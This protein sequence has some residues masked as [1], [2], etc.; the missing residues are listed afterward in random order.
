L[1]TSSGS[2]VTQGLKGGLDDVVGV[3]P[4]DQV[5]V[6]VYP[7]VYDEGPEK[8]LDEPGVEM[9]DHRLIDIDPVVEVRPAREI[10]A[11]AQERLVHREA[12]GGE[13]SDPPLHAEGL[14]EGV[15]QHDTRIFDQ[16]MEIDL[17]IPLRVYREVEPSVLREELEKV[18][19]KGDPGVYRVAPLSVEVEGEI[20]L[21][22]FRLP[23]H[24][25]RA[26]LFHGSVPPFFLVF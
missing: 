4:A 21:R 16:M 24:V 13:P 17:D 22:L 7:R 23:F 12:E 2:V 3:L 18:V 15:S 5:D 11:H 1:L 6:E 9:N 10:D 26:H 20:D 8:F 19:E 25:G 14:P